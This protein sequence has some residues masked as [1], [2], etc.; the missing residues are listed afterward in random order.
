MP[1]QLELLLRGG[2]DNPCVCASSHV[3]LIPH[4]LHACEVFR[5]DNHNNQ[6]LAEV[7]KLLKYRLSRMS[8]SGTGIMVWVFTLYIIFGIWTL[9]V[10]AG[11]KGSSWHGTQFYVH[12][13]SKLPLLPSGSG[14]IQS[15]GRAS[16][17]G[18]WLHVKAARLTFTE[19]PCSF[20]VST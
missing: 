1:I 20:M 6:Y 9:R 15:P 11:S 4:A 13:R 16:G 3:M 12:L 8:I 14:S 7:S 10:V 19:A 18:L 17:E 5:T 2:Q